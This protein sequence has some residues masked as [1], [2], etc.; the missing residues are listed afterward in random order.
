MEQLYIIFNE[1]NL[2]EA[3]FDNYDSFLATCIEIEEQEERKFELD[4]ENY[5]KNIYYLSILQY[6]SNKYGPDYWMDR[7]F[8]MVDI[9]TDE[10]IE[11]QR[12]K[13]EDNSYQ[14]FYLDTDKYILYPNQ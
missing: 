7:E 8:Y 2:V 5:E 3:M 9:E 14:L 13:A 12:Y 10:L 1:D 6:D 11:I 4:K